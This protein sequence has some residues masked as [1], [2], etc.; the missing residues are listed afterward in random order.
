MIV[1]HKYLWTC[2]ASYGPYLFSFFSHNCRIQNK[3]NNVLH[4]WG[5]KNLANDINNEVR[6]LEIKKSFQQERPRNKLLKLQKFLKP[7]NNSV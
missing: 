7:N 6:K 3:L 5:R 2:D 1:V 4:K